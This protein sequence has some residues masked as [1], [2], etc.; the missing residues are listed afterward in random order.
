M[1]LQNYVGGAWKRVRAA[2]SVDVMNPATGEVLAVVPITGAEEVDAA[3]GG[4]RRPVRRAG[5]GPTERPRAQFLFRLK[6]LL[7]ENL[8]ALAHCITLE[9]G[10]LFAEARGEVRRAID[11]I[12]MACGTPVHLQGRFSEDIAAA[13]TRP[14]SAN[15]SGC[16]RRSCRSTSP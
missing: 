12:E 1:D 4:R 2:S 7:E 15:R 16:A 6:A 9:H 8:E 5:G 13:S 3:G 11:N 14:L 10:K